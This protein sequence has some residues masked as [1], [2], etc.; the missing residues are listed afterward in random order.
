MKKTTFFILSLLLVSAVNTEVILPARQ[1]EAG[2]ISRCVARVAARKAA[3]RAVVR[4]SVRKAS[5][6]SISKQALASRQYKKI[7]KRD[8]ARDAATAAK[9]IKR[10]RSVYRY[11]SWQEAQAAKKTGIKAGSHMTSG[12]RRGRPISAETARQRYG[13]GNKPSAR[14]K[15]RIP[16]GHPV[17]MNKVIGGKPGWGEITSTKKISPK[18]IES[19]TKVK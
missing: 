6:K 3:R 11:T 12:V 4:S 17:R 19:I 16:K 7:L 18:Y 13:L 10:E 2:I 8:A 15:I 14:I 1:V 5:R 9:P